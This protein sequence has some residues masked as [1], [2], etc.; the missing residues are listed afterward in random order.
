[1][2]AA[3]VPPGYMP[4]P[5]GF[6]YRALFLHGRPRH[7]K[8]DDFWRRHPPMDP[9]HRAKIFSAFDA[10]SGFSDC[11]AEARIASERIP[12]E[13]SSDTYGKDYPPCSID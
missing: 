3:A 10:L 4:M 12:P 1:M 2:S 7:Q 9:R 11:L 8:Y 6:P 5:A 13:D